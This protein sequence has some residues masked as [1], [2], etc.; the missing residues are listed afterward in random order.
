MADQLTLPTVIQ[1]SQ[2]QTGMTVR[3]HQ[4][5]KDIAPSGEEKERVQVYEGLVTKTSGAGV[6]KTMTVRKISEGVGVEKIF[7][8]TLPAIIKVELTKIVKTSRKDISLSEKQET[9]KRRKEF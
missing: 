2:I 8:L 6:R 5:I 4:K 3:I 9:S 7:P 1:P